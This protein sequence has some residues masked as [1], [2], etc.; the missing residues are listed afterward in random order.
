[1]AESI[2]TH[3]EEDSYNSKAIRL[4]SSITKAGVLGVPV[5]QVELK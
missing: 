4:A 3:L 2:A 5:Y 1:M